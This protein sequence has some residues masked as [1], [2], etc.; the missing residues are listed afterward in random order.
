MVEEAGDTDREEN[1]AL[2]TDLCLTGK[3]SLSYGNDLGFADSALIGWHAPLCAAAASS[4]NSRSE[5]AS[6]S[7]YCW[8]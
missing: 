1:L 2:E 6:A 8:P 4:K 3:S 5:N 7:P